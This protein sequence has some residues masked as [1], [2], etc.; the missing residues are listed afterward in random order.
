LNNTKAGW[1]IYIELAKRM[2]KGEYFPF[3][4]IEDIWQYQLQDTGP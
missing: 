2:G 4:S 1:E 3:N